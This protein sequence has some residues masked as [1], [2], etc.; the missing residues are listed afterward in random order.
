MVKGSFSFNSRR[1]EDERP[2]KNYPQKLTTQRQKS[3]ESHLSSTLTRVK[4]V[5]LKGFYSIREG[6]KKR[7]GI[8]NVKGIRCYVIL[9]FGA[10]I[11]F[12]LPFVIC[13]YV[14]MF[15]M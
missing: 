15:F 6:Y 9:W 13:L 8:S 3:F 2:S 1:T 12:N 11:Y 10:F 14:V 7:A 4:L 5:V